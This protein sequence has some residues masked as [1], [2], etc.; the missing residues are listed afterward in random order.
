VVL[1]S[2]EQN[3][4]TTTKKAH[5]NCLCPNRMKSGCCYAR[6]YTQQSLVHNLLH[7]R[8]RLAILCYFFLQILV[9][10]T[11]ITN[12]RRNALGNVHALGEMAD[13]DDDSYTEQC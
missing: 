11:T 7:A 13:D 5:K 9:V 10:H 4:T 3:T 2:N 8:P 6:I 12:N 1:L